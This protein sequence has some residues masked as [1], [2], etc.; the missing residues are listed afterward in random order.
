[1]TTVDA[2]ALHAALDAAREEA[3]W[4]WRRLARELSLSASTMSRLLSGNKPDVDAFATMVS[5]LRVDPR[6][7]MVD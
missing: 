3:G 2:K 5:W 1:M 4:S 7:F 6:R